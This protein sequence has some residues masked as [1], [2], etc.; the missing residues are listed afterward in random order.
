MSRRLVSCVGVAILF[1]IT[2]AFAQGEK[3]GEVS[4]KSDVFPII[5]A[6]CLPCH[7]EDNFNPSELSMDSYDGL[8]N[9]GK[10]GAPVKAGKAKESLLIEKIGEKPKF[11]DKMPLNSKKKIAE[12]KAVYL[13][14]DEIKSIATWIDQGAKNN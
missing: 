7:A 12:G 8:V 3:K 4:F 2:I 9:G 5:K 6:K 14:A 10:H 1:S 13:S 11:G